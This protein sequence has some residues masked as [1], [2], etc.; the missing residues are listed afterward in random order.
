MRKFNAQLNVDDYDGAFFRTCPNQQDFKRVSALP[1][2]DTWQMLLLSGVAAHMP[3]DMSLNPQ[4]D[5]T[6]TN[7][8]AEQ[9]R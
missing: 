6:Y 3:H 7:Y 9:V 1:V 4:G 8:V 5:T 2:D